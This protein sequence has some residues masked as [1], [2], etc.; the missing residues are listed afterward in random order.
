MVERTNYSGGEEED[1]YGDE[2][3]GEDE[4]WMDWEHSNEVSHVDGFE[5]EESKGK[6]AGFK[7]MHIDE[8]RVSVK[9]KI[10][11]LKEL[12]EMDNDNLIHV[13]RYYHWN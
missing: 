7:I 5:L 1:W 6:D 11:E 13:A 2:N 12:F 9:A 3:D 10:D 8:I 4:A